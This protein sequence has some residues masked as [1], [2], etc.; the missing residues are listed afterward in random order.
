MS[1]ALRITL[2]WLLTLAVPV[3]GFAAASMLGCAGSQ[4][5]LA[6]LA[7]AHS[8]ASGH[9][10]DA[11]FMHFQSHDGEGAEMAQAAQ[12]AHGDA[13]SDTDAHKRHA[14]G[15]A[16]AASCSACAACCT[17]AALPAT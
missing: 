4:H 8:H 16:S 13:G 6:A 1:R 5:H 12:H 10:G 7:G 14:D 15:K 2:M 11:A 17:S 3:H 9:H